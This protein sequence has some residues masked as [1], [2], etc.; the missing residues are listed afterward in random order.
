MFWTFVG[1][2]IVVAGGTFALIG[3]I[4]LGVKL[5]REAAALDEP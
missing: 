2:V 1:L 3:T 4:A 5:G